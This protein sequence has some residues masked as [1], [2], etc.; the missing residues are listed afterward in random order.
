MNAG[1]KPAFFV[2]YM[3]FF[4][5]ILQSQ[6]NN[7]FYKGSTDDLVRRITEHNSGK[8]FSTKRYLP[9]KLVWFTTKETKSE[10]V[11]LEMKL[12]NLSIQRTIDFIEKYPV[13]KDVFEIHPWV[14]P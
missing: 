2:S 12:K 6:V 5:Y 9:W 3:A 4:V 14:Q 8:S 11:K 1:Q 10:A 13:S 7:S